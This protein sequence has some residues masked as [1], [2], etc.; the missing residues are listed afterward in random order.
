MNEEA[1][2]FYQ[3]QEW[4]D[5]SKVSLVILGKRGS[6]KSSLVNSLSG[7][8]SCVVRPVGSQLPCTRKSKGI[9]VRQTQ[10]VT[11]DT[12]GWQTIP[13]KE[14]NLEKYVGNLDQFP[15]AKDYHLVIYTIDISMPE[16]ML[17]NVDVMKLLSTKFKGIWDNSVIALTYADKYLSELKETNEDADFSAE[18]KRHTKKLQSVLKEDLGLP[19]E[20]AMSIPI[21]ATGLEVDPP[22][23]PWL[24]NF[25]L[26]IFAAAKLKAKPIVADVCAAKILDRSTGVHAIE[27]S[28][29]V[30]ICNRNYKEKAI[31]LAS[32]YESLNDGRITV[33][34]SVSS[35][36]YLYQNVLKYH[37]GIQSTEVHLGEN[38]H[39]DYWKS[40]SNSIDILVA[41][42]LSSGKTALINS[43]FCGKEKI[44]EE[45][46][47]NPG[48]LKVTP[49]TDLVQ[50]EH[51][52]CQVWD[53]PGLDEL[54]SLE[55]YK[56]CLPSNIGLFFFCIE[57][58]CNKLTTKKN[59]KKLTEALGRSIW[60]H[61]VIILTLANTSL[62]N[63]EMEFQRSSEEVK[64]IMKDIDED[65]DVS[66]CPAGYHTS[67]HIPNDPEDRFWCL[68]VWIN[69][70][71]RA[72]SEH[73]LAL[74]ELLNSN[75]KLHRS[76]GLEKS[77]L[78]RAI[79]LVKKSSIP[80]I[81]EK[82]QHKIT[83]LLYSILKNNHLS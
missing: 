33:V 78:S 1:N 79:S 45:Q 22:G 71:T 40:L 34:S 15:L 6:G 77:L 43:L 19:N 25:W 69:A 46:S 82:Y 27:V 73:Q 29:L 4:K 30:N 2:L 26:S 28:R 18:I 24:N 31:E 44:P 37:C 5:K 36:L 54:Q 35:F 81:K 12:P 50:H 68:D 60:E 11:W 59:I 75:Y 7:S 13:E 20:L 70:I 51:I 9:S 41:G 56:T 10:L 16:K 55:S 17:E 63:F 57:I 83:E 8:K 21:V 66:V 52:K 80:P 72:K 48:T 49:H 67:L 39:L 58:A 53:T 47:I 76:W 74:I 32:D 64:K 38:R 61:G 42:N 23:M 14:N 3:L 65:I 62:E